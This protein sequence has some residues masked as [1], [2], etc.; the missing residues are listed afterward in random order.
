MNVATFTNFV[1]DSQVPSLTQVSGCRMSTR[2][3][4]RAALELS[5]SASSHNWQERTEE[6]LAIF[7]TEHPTTSGSFGSF[8]F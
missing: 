6:L 4:V 8:L 1:E 5:L 2:K 7:E 3:N